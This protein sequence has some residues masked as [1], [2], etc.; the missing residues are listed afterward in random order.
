MPESK[1][2]TPRATLPPRHNRQPP[3]AV[4]IDSGGAGLS[5]G[6]TPIA[7][8][9]VSKRFSAR[10]RRLPALPPAPSCA[11]VRNAKTLNLSV[12]EVLATLEDRVQDP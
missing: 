5:V 4:A 1:L 11:V 10:G 7:C 9:W 8:A 2:K 3:A 12:D 6:D